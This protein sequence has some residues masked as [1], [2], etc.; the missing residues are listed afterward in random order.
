MTEQQMQKA[1]I[2]LLE[3]EYNAYVV[4]VERASKAGVPDL[5]ACVEGKFIAIEVKLPKTKNNVSALQQY[6][7]DKVEEAG[8]F[9]LVAWDIEVVKEFIESI[10]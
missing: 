7:L 6:N 3:T 9:S 10:L 2:K 1:I 4:K 5:L 8:G